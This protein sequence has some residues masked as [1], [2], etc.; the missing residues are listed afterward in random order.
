VSAKWQTLNQLSKEQKRLRKVICKQMQ[1]S[2]LKSTIKTFEG[3]FSSEKVE[4]AKNF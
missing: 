3:F 1:K 2:G 4:D